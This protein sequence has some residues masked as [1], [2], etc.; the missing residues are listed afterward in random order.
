MGEAVRRLLSHD[1]HLRLEEQSVDTQSST[2]AMSWP[3]PE[4]SR[5]MP[6]WPWRSELRSS[7]SSRVAPA[8]H[9]TAT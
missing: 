4:A 1:E 9:A 7:P 8:A 5:P 6:R 3:W 2:R